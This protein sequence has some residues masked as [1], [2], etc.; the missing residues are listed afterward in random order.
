MEVWLTRFAVAVIP[1]L[2]RPVVVKLAHGLGA[3]ASW[4]PGKTK[5]IAAANLDIAFG[6]T[7]SAKQ[8]QQI[9]RQSCQTFALVLLDI[10]WFSKHTRERVLAHTQF[11][12]ELAA[13]LFQPKAQLCITGHLG[14]W[15]LLGHAV[16]VRGYP[17]HSI[18]A[19]LVNPAVEPYFLKT[20]TAS[21]QVIF[22]RDGA[23]RAML[24]TL[25]QG[26]K[27]GLLLDQNTSPAE[28]GIFV[29]FF[30]LK[31]PISDAAIALAKKTDA[32]LPF[33]FC[34]PDRRG[35]YTA[36][37]APAIRIHTLEGEDA[38]A[39]GTQM[40]ATT[41]ETAIRRH[42]HAWLWGYRRWRFIPA[43]ADES[44]YPF[45]AKR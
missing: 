33:G 32:D 21:G 26:N 2:P 43:G 9:Y 1:S 5:R 20:R 15:E 36:Y 25:K 6:D 37:T 40:I 38:I 28:G 12:P 44:R 41:L 7:L 11:D 45:Y 27:V 39:T 24:R 16:S 3:V 30:G 35:N 14:N 19:P 13:E 10:F 29:D 18:A 22:S 31:A 34:I 17:L 42:P 23:V 8:K 4:L